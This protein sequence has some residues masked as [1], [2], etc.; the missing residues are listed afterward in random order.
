MYKVDFKLNIYNEEY[1]SIILSSFP[2]NIIGNKKEDYILTI[3]LTQFL[4]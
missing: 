4:A 2:I 1:E 3:I